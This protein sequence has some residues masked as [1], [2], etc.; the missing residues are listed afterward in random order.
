MAVGQS[1]ALITILNIGAGSPGLLSRS[2]EEE[3][4][5]FPKIH[6]LGQEHLA[7]A[8]LPEDLTIVSY[9]EILCDEDNPERFQMASYRLLE[10]CSGQDGLLIVADAMPG[11]MQVCEE[12]FRLAADG[13]CRLRM[14]DVHG[15]FAILLAAAGLNFTGPF[16]VISAAE[17]TRFHHPS[18]PPGTPALLPDLRDEATAALTRKV[19]ENVYPAEHPVRVVR[20]GMDQEV[21]I[22]DISLSGLDHL[23][24]SYSG[25]ALIV[26]PLP[27]DTSFEAFQEIIAALRAPDGCPWD[28]EQT[29]LTLRKNLLEETYEALTA[30][31]DED[32]DGMREELGDILLQIVLHAQIAYE[33]GEFRMED[34]IAGINRKLV[35]RHPHVFGEARVSGV[36]GVLQNWERL[37]EEERAAKGQHEKGQLEGVPVSLPA[38]NQAQ[39]IQS[40]AARVGFDWPEI[41]PVM[42]KVFE[43]I[44]EVETAANAEEREKEIGDLFFAVVNLARW[45]KVDAESALRLTNLKFRKRFAY[46]EKEARVKGT[47]LADMTLEEMDVLWE[48]AKEFD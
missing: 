37:K 26:P 35:H 38:L 7:N 3:I 33:A 10:A 47:R 4:N 12:L 20:V 2:M 14:L 27:E 21:T 8:G 48:A 32:V 34:V 22:Q 29:H 9:E 44:E 11:R 17:L 13:H 18:F 6:T 15:N 43:E 23:P 25:A 46:I 45:Y 16:S 5:R 42:G 41:K 36:K 24:G 40:R 31:D 39:E 1:K 28:R 19:L 30:F